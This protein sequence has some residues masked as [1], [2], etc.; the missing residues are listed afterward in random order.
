[1]KST[2]FIMSI[3]IRLFL[4]IQLRAE[5]SH[6]DHHQ[7]GIPRCHE[8]SAV[9]C[10]GRLVIRVEETGCEVEAAVRYSLEGRVVAATN[11]IREHC[12]PFEMGTRE[13][14]EA[15][16]TKPH[17]NPH[18]WRSSSA[19]LEQGLPSAP[20]CRRTPWRPPGHVPRS[21]RSV[22]YAYLAVHLK[23]LYIS[24][25]RPLRQRSI[26]QAGEES[27]NSS[28]YAATT[29]NGDRLCQ[30]SICNCSTRIRDR[31][32]DEVTLSEHRAYTTLPSFSR[33]LRWSQ[34]A[35]IGTMVC[36]ATALR[37]SCRTIPL[38]GNSWHRS[39]VQR[40]SSL[41]RHASTSFR[42]RQ[43]VGLQDPA[44]GFC[45]RRPDAPTGGRPHR[46][47]PTGAA[48][49]LGSGHRQRRGTQAVETKNGFVVEIGQSK[50]SLRAAQLM[51]LPGVT[52]QE[53]V[54]SSC[55]AVEGF[56]IILPADG[57]FM[58][59]RYAHSQSGDTLAAA[60]NLAL[61]AG[62]FSSRSRTLRLSRWESCT[63]SAFSNLLPECAAT[64][65]RSLRQRSAACCT[66]Y[67]YIFKSHA[68][69]RS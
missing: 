21:A 61:G 59:C 52:A 6:D 45:D 48:P 31:G 10:A 42:Q 3:C 41:R 63:S 65:G 35:T 23:S 36:R 11:K 60:S 15:S 1:M 39:G 58:A 4:G 62:G 33:R 64:S 22:S 28:L 26:A 40:R 20:S 46:S 55:A 51:A 49:V 19:A 56:S 50:K 16:R 66:S 32:A 67:L 25:P 7:P 2:Q 8:A 24:P 9:S 13:A 5:L 27:I 37:R 38:L 43:E 44:L 57:L 18:L 53:R 69:I 68:T 54:Q 12:A 34:A 47:G 30:S 14:L 17:I 29:V